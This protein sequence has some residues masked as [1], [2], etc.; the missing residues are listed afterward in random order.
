MVGPSTRSRASLTAPYPSSRRTWTGTGTWT[1]SRPPCSTT[2]SPG[3]RTRPSTGGRPTL[4]R[5]PFRRRPPGRALSRRWTWMGMVTSTPYRPPVTITRLPGTRT[6]PGT[7]PRGRGIRSLTR[8][9]MPHRSPPGTWMATE[10]PTSSRLLNTTTRSPG[11]RTRPET[12]LRGQITR[13]RRRPM[14]R[15][16]SMRRMWTGTG[17]WTFSPPP[18]MSA[19][20]RTWRATVRSG[21]TTRSQPG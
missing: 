13:S 5:W 6:R 18:T 4:P 14:A 16:G 9:P 10:T 15:G 21:L 2:R 8:A 1:S 3:T 12:A 20:T 19:G 17:T 11:T 7:A